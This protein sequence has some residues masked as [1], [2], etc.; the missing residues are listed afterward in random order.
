MRNNDFRYCK[1]FE[2]FLYTSARAF[3]T[4]LLVLLLSQ[5]QIKKLVRSSIHRIPHVPAPLSLLL[6][7]SALAPVVDSTLVSSAPRTDPGQT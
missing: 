7:V 4:S 6:L 5:Q 3:F 2:S 1:L